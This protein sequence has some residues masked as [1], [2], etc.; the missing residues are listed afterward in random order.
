MNR[1]LFLCCLMVAML[2]S[3]AQASVEHGVINRSAL[4][5]MKPISEKPLVMFDKVSAAQAKQALGSINAA[6]LLP[7][8]KAMGLQLK[9]VQAISQN[10]QKHGIKPV[11][12]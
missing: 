11:T 7:P 12:D 10:L 5:G 8:P 9:Q 2:G 3:T 1:I 6:N 4:T